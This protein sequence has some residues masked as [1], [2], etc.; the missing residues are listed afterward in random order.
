[1]HFLAIFLVLAVPIAVYMIAQNQKSEK[2]LIDANQR[3]VDLINNIQG[4]VITCLF[5]QK[6]G[7]SRT[8][9]INEGW[10]V[11]TGYSLEQLQNELGGNPQALILPEDRESSNRAYLAQTV[12]GNSYKLEYRV[13]R[14]DGSV[15]WVLDRGIITLDTDG[16]LQNQ[17]II[18]DVTDI[19][20]QE[21]EL[22][23]MAQM[24]PLT[25]LYNKVACATLIQNNLKIK[26]GGLHALMMLDI[27]NFKGINDSLGHI[28]GDTVLIEVS[29]RL[30]RLFRSHDVI[31][32]I[33]GDEFLIFMV[34]IASKEAAKQKAEEVCATFRNTYM[35]ESENYKISA[36]LGIVFSADSLDYQTLLHW[37]DIALYQAKTKGK[38]QYVVY[39]ADSEMPMAGL[40]KR[41]FGKDS[42]PEEKDSG[43]L[44]MKERFFELLYGSVDLSGSIN[45]ALALLGRI[46][47][48]SR[49][50]VVENTR[51]AQLAS[52]TYEWCGSGVASC[53][54]K[55][56]AVPI[57]KVGYLDLFDEN[58][59]F[60]CSNIG[61]LKP[62]ISALCWQEKACSSMQ[63][64]FSENGKICGFIGF[65]DFLKS[66][67]PSKEKMNMMIFAAKVIGVFI[68]KKR[69]EE[70]T[71]L[72]NQSKMAALDALPNII[73]VIDSEFKV[74]YMNE[75]TQAT[76]P[77]ATLG[78]CC[79]DVFMAKKAPCSNC[80]AP[81]CASQGA[82]VEI[83]NP[84]CQLRF[85]SNASKITWHG[86]KNMVIICCQNITNLYLEE[87]SLV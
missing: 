17:S 9:Y 13:A 58:G 55:R 23:K 75:L 52:N 43:E 70:E 21:E 60:F 27:D 79:Y 2:K 69:A 51:D 39:S 63:V 41:H 15:I 62:E 5:D 76:F 22:R 67:K 12:V 30:Q 53:L 78:A 72:Y 11:L 64:A 59:V 46:M 54:K 10:Q 7:T 14:K 34:D 80:P 16:N 35:G 77:K 31:G 20:E 57:G 37:A 25:G 42:K 26:Q 50:Y 47:E 29:A 18:T 65:D 19:K 1:M 71:S 73:Y 56:Q 74:H 68:L 84:Y 24:D 38:D 85:L 44:E 28:F 82:C 33:G 61:E 3:Y 66:E 4:G 48:V 6:T 86:Q 87:S 36:S 40:M 81:E 83:Y 45:M 32:R 8:L 49:V